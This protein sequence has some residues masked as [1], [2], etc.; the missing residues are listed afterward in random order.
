MV[1][2]EDGFMMDDVKVIIYINVIVIFKVGDKMVI[3]KF[4]NS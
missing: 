3:V 2:G 1:M 4:K